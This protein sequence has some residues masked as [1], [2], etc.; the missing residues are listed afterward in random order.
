MLAGI[1]FWKGFQSADDPLAPYRDRIMYPIAIIGVACLLPFA[2]NNFIQGRY[3]LGIAILGMVAGLTADALAIRWERTPP[4]P[5]A[6]LLLPAMASITISLQTQGIFGSFWCFPAVLFFYFVLSRRMANLCSTALLV[7][8]TYMVDHY[9]GRGVAI[10]FGVALVL[11][12]VV[13]NIVQNVIRDLQTQLVAQTITDPLTGAYNRRYFDARAAEA[14]E[15]TRRRAAAASLLMIDIDHFKR[16]ND[17]FGHAAGDS[18]LKALVATMG[19]RLRK[20]DLVFRIGG[21]EFVV[22]LPDTREA[23]ARAVAEELRA[24]VERA[25]LHPRAQVTVSIGVAGLHADETPEAWLKQADQALYAAK[26]AGR[27]RVA[28]AE[29]VRG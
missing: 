1:P 27:N 11:T 28:A 12:I 8:A 17:Q 2:I 3:P 13:I 29:A 10:R 15:T 24:A 4:I 9:I 21:E 20:L 22:L 18:V 6:L 14:I 19:Y 25:R 5:F 26:H 16:L 23:E 7:E